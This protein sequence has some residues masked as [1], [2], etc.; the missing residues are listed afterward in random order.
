MISFATLDELRGAAG[1]ALGVTEWMEISQDRV[2]LFADATGDHQWIHVDV[3][4][5]RAESAFGGPVAHG[6]LT[7]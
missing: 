4:R 5:A 7:V 2:D 6:L 3:E 1:Q